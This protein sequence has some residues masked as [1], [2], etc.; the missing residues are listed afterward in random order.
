MTWPQP[1]PAHDA[2]A[3]AL[4]CAGCHAH[5]RDSSPFHLTAC[6]PILQPTQSNDIPSR[7]TPSKPIQAQFPS[8]PNSH[9]ILSHL[10]LAVLTTVCAA[11]RGQS[12]VFLTLGTMFLWVGWSVQRATGGNTTLSPS[13][14]CCAAPHHAPPRR[15][16]CHSAIQHALLCCA[17]PRSSPA[18]PPGLASTSVL[19]QIY[20]RLAPLLCLP[21]WQRSPC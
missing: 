21:G 4:A 16:P 12:A 19:C 6:H 10:T 1:W 13:M 17:P 15:C 14:R 20:M 9:P 5:W 3:T 2:M 7:L 11:P 18:T 8:Q